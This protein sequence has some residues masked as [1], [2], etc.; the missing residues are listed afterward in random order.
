MYMVAVGLFLIALSV[1]ILALA[2][3]RVPHRRR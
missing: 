1:V 2:F 3:P